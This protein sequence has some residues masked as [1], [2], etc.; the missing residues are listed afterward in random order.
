[1]VEA[2]AL[3]PLR[4]NVVG[5]L[6]A[7]GVSY[8]G[9][10]RLTFAGNSAP[11]LQSAGRFFVISASAFAINEL[12]YAILLHVSTIRYDFLLAGVLVGV[13]VLTYLASRHWAFA[14]TRR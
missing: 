11:L 8:A 14:G 3:A 6:C 10:Y 4:A 7:F 2:L 1:V 13:A 9:H 5:W 12:S